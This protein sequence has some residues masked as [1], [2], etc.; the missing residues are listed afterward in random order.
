MLDF[1]F[2]CTKRKAGAQPSAL[3]TQRAYAAHALCVRCGCSVSRCCYRYL[4]GCRAALMNGAKPL[5][6]LGL[7]SRVRRWL[8][9]GFQRLDEESGKILPC[10]P[11]KGSTA[12]S[13]WRWPDPAT[14]V[15]VLTNFSLTVVVTLSGL[16]LMYGLQLLMHAGVIDKEY[17]MGLLALC[18]PVVTMVSYVAP[19]PVVLE[20]VRTSDA[21]TMPTLVFQLQAVCNVLSISYGIKIVNMAVLVTNMFGLVCQLLFLGADHYVRQSNSQWLS[22]SLKGAVFF[23]ITLHVTATISPL[24]IL[25]YSITL[26]NI[27]MFAAPL[28]NL[29]TILQTKNPSPL[30]TPM[31]TLSLLNNGVW[32]M[33]AMLIEDI[34]VLLPS[35]LGYAMAAFQAQV[36]LWC[37]GF[38]PFDLAYLLL[39]MACASSRSSA[40]SKTVT[41]SETRV[42]DDRIL[43]CADRK[44]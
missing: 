18:A 28:A 42:A 43:L 38:L 23:N 8:S 15:S 4:G 19:L 29:G 10:S 12:S 5:G 6:L 26:F 39:P 11:S 34:V 1:R 3:G 41:P 17:S 25:G 2:L 44:V 7:P 21:Q 22:F 33:Y 37:K 24:T 30:P 32:V 40:E 9:G 27:L 20:C 36:I 14:V 31:V 35:V 16:A 13:R